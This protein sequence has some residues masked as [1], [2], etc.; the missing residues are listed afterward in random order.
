VGR[1]RIMSQ[2]PNQTKTIKGKIIKHAFLNMKPFDIYSV[3]VQAL[4]A[5]APYSPT[6][7]KAKFGRDIL[8]GVLGKRHIAQPGMFT[9]ANRP[10]FR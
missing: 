4:P 6:Y 9:P 3:G 10:L 1:R 5:V 2:K 8:L 7:Q